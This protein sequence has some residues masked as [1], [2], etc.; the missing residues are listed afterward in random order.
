MITRR[1]L[2]ASVAV[3]AGLAPAMPALAFDRTVVPAP[4]ALRPFQFPDWQEYKLANGLP[5]ILVENHRTPV[6]SC[7][8]ILKG[9]ADT[10][11]AGKS[12]RASLAASLW[13]KGTPTHTAS[14]IDELVDRYGAT[15]KASADRAETTLGLRTVSTHFD[16]LL[17]LFADVAMHPALPA[18]EV[19]QAKELKLAALKQSADKVG[20][21]ARRALLQTLFPDHPYGELPQGSVAGVERIEQADLQAFFREQLVP[22]NALL[23]VA[24]DFQPKALL[25]KLNALPIGKAPAGKAPAFTLPAAKPAKAGVVLV[26]KPGAVQSALRIGTLGL[27]PKDPDYAAWTVANAMLGGLFTSRLNANLREDKGYTYGAGS[28]FTSWAQSGYITAATDVETPHTVASVA[29]VLKEFARLR[30]EPVAA[31]ELAKAKAYLIGTFPNDFGTAAQVGATVANLKLLGLPPSHV[32]G[33][34]DRIAKVTGADVQRVAHR[35]L[36]PDHLTIV[37]AGDA[38]KLQALA[39][40]GTMTVVSAGGEVIARP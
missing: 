16:T 27:T 19:T 38:Q 10:D 35:F 5:V 21:L 32:R 11:P 3:L 24:G 15:L 17:P 39:Q 28:S 18:T 14:Q 8:L 12:G 9:G 30:N 26:D 13:T 31:D 1:F 20:D 37:V 23:V 36:K 25:Q 2:A 6:V 22:A 7:M 40:F 34:R 4:G 33:F 29:E